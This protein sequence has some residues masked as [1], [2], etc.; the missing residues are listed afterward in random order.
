MST[1]AQITTIRQQPRYRVLDYVRVHDLIYGYAPTLQEM[2]R[3]LGLSFSCV[4]VH[5]QRLADDGALRRLP[6]ARGYVPTRE[7]R[8]GKGAC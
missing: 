2:Q 1:L 6:G 8:F 7:L 5:L 3:A 4:R